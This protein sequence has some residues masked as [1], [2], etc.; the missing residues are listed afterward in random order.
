[1]AGDGYYGRRGREG[2]EMRRGR[3]MDIMGGEGGRIIPVMTTRG[4]ALLI[5]W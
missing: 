5:F 1:M 4:V 3:G 2:Y